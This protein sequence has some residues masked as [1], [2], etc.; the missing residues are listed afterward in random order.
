MSN[1]YQ[2]NLDPNYAYTPQ[3]PAPVLAGWPL[4]FASGLIDFVITA[5]VAGIASLASQGLGYVVELIVL[6][7]FGVLEGTRAQT[8]G[9]MVVGLR[10]VQLA[11][12]SLLGAGL[13]IGRRLLHILD[14]I[15]CFVG[16]L[17]PL[18]DEK[19]QT[20]ADKIVKSVVVKVQ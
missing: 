7:V 10:T 13:G 14:T 12:G 15:A 17:W 1:P 9:K 16:Y 4:R 2:P 6:I 20:F 19:R 8:P 11:D 3:P 18:W 5:V